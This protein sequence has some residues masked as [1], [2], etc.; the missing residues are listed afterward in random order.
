M[1]NFEGDVQPDRRP[2][3][4]A[5][6]GDKAESLGAKCLQQPPVC[7]SKEVPWNREYFKRRIN[8]HSPFWAKKRTTKNEI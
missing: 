2:E 3:L 8:I 6:G 4:I 7:A 5:W 1:G